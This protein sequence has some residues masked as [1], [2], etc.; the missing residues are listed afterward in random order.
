LPDGQLFRGRGRQ[1]QPD[2]HA[3][4]RGITLLEVVIA[5]TIFV[6]TLPAL[7]ALVQYG[8]ERAEETQVLALASL[9]C[10]SKMAEVQAGSVPMTSADWAPLDDPNWY[11]RIDAGNASG[12]TGMN[13]IQVWVKLDAGGRSFESTLIQMVLDPAQRGSTLDRAQ[14]EPTTSNSTASGSDSTGSGGSS[15][16]SGNTSG[17]SGATSVGG[18]GMPAAGGASGKTGGTS[19][20]TGGTSGKTGGATGGAGTGASRGGAGMTGGGTGTG[21][22][23]GTGGGMG[24]GG[25]AG[26]GAR[27]TT[28]KGG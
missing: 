5:L 24:T 22:A 12:I 11:F 10:R 19:G 3:P 23:T 26:T 27:G 1:A 2:L 13:T 8:T 25:G 18:G 17:A 20:K 16:T 28:G 6:M 15:N 4:R 9:Q 14:L 21:G 7:N